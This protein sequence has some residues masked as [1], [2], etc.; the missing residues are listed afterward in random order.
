MYQQ[1]AV[2]LATSIRNSLMS[3]ISQQVLR[4]DLAAAQATSAPALLSANVNSIQLGFRALHDTWSSL[5]GTAIALWLLGRELGVSVAP[6][7]VL[8]FGACLCI[9]SV[10]VGTDIHVVLIVASLLLSLRAGPRQK[11]WFDAVGRRVAATT[12]I[13]ANMKGMK[14]MGCQRSVHS[15]L[16]AARRDEIK[17]S[18][19]F[20]IFLI[21][22]TTLC[23]P[24]PTRRSSNVDFHLLF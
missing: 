5:I 13:L 16:S 22:I 4:L 24:T 15:M 20:R 11:I 1:K 17:R 9:P 10:H 3:A 8:S 14:L 21:M 18:Q 6:T 19:S 2:R 7:A 23:K 12:A